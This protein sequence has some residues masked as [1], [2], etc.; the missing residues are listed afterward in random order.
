VEVSCFATAVTFKPLVQIRPLQPE[1]LSNMSA[2][3]EP[4]EFARLNAW[5]ELGNARHRRNDLTLD[6]APGCSF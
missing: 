1:S 6:Y 5:L 4:F 3:L 2:N